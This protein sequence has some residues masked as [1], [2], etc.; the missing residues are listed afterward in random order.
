MRGL[1]VISKCSNLQL[2]NQIKKAKLNEV[3]RKFYI[4]VRLNRTVSSDGSGKMT[5]IG[6][7]ASCQS[8]YAELLAEADVS[9]T[10]QKKGPK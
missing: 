6:K 7:L 8:A 1:T 9:Q 10:K 4:Y 2:L 3:G 5:L